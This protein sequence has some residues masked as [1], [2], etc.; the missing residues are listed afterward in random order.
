M[1][2]NLTLGI[3]AALA[4]AAILFVSLNVLIYKVSRE[5]PPAPL[6]PMRPS[7]SQRLWTLV[8]KASKFLARKARTWTPVL[9]HVV[10]DC[11]SS[12]STAVREYVPRRRLPQRT[13]PPFP[14]ERT[15]RIAQ[16]HRPLSAAGHLVIVSDYPDGKSRAVLRPRSRPTL[17]VVLGE[18]DTGPAA[19]L[20]FL[21]QAKAHRVS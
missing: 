20:E 13:P 21:R 10:K 9:V 16:C 18:L 8:L 3:V 14:A 7:P 12:L 17:R 6:Y 2:D 15:W 1:S 11:Y 5:K 19:D 4:T